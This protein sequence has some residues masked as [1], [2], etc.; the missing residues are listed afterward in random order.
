MTTG[1]DR[2]TNLGRPRPA[3]ALSMKIATFKSSKPDVV[4]LQELRC[5]D[6]DFPAEAIKAAGYA[7]VWRG[8]WTSELAVDP[9]N[10]PFVAN[11]ARVTR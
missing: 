9:F 8:Q 11:Y 4:R 3:L 6:A 5:A 7:E 1:R 10:G 2:D